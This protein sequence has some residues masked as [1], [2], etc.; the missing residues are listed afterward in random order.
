MFLL[1]FDTSSVPKVYE[2]TLAV[3][4]L[5]CFFHFWAYV[6]GPPNMNDPFRKKEK[7]L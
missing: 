5:G 6:M 3:F 4:Y 1:N 7:K 2:Y